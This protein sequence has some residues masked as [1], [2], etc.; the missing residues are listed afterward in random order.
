MA[1]KICFVAAFPSVAACYFYFQ[2]TAYS[3]GKEFWQL[4]REIFLQICQKITRVG[5]CKFRTGL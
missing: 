3:I 4:C 5:T 2:N 1:T